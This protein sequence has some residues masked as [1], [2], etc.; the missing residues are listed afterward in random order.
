MTALQGLA[1]K[2]DDIVE[3]RGKG[4]LVGMELNRPARPVGS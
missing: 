3:V 4:L 1:A 2:R